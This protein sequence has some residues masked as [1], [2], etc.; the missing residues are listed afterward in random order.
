MK[1]IL[2]DIVAHTNTLD[3]LNLLRVESNEEETTI[4]C[5][6]DD[7]NIIMLARTHKP[8]TEFKGLFGMPNLEKLNLHLKN[9]EYQENATIRVVSEKRNGEDVLTHIHFENQHGDFK[10]DYRLAN[11]VLVEEKMKKVKFKGASWL[12]DFN[13]TKSA[14]D[15]LKLM[16]V[17]HREEPKFNVFT[18]KN[19]E[20][21]DLIFSF[22]DASNH[23]GEYVFQSNVGTELKHTWCWSVGLVG[24]VLTLPGDISMK[25][26]DQGAMM[27]S[28][29]SGIALY[30]YIMPALMN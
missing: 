22:G 18:R 25:I 28:V 6:S 20:N 1:D 4:E 3:S 2:L 13:P 17:V 7:K 14:I 19:N 8:I 5:V 26:S 10:N 21:I 27:I 29:D 9:P 30:E 24:S 12:I 23:A 15:R 16:N 11:K